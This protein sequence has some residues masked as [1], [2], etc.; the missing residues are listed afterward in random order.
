MVLY[1]STAKDYHATLLCTKGTV[2]EQP[3]ILDKVDNKSRLPVRLEINDIAKSAVGKC[4][5]EYID[6][7]FPAPVV[8]AF[9]VVDAL[10]DLCNDFGWRKDCALLFLLLMHL[11]N[12][13]Q[14]PLLKQGVVLVRHDQISDSVQA[15][16]TKCLSF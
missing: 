11:F 8:D 13:G 3:D 5:T 14:E 2:I 15:L 12:D 7:V 6:A 1:N 4:G 10:S 9:F 16:V